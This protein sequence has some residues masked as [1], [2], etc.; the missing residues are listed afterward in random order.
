[1]SRT[2]Y[3]RVR[4]KPFSNAGTISRRGIHSSP[5]RRAARASTS[6][7]SS[8]GRR[9]CRRA[10]PHG[11][12][13]RGKCRRCDP[14]DR[15]RARDHREHGTGMRE[16]ATGTSRRAT[17]STESANSSSV[18]VPS[19]LGR[20]GGAIRQI[21]GSSCSSSVSST[22]VTGHASSGPFA[23]RM[24]RLPTGEHLR[25]STISRGST[26]HFTPVWTRTGTIRLRSRSSGFR[27]V[28]STRKVST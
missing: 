4:G 9:G 23:R 19:R 17:G 3:S 11:K 25:A 1:M 22:T 18:T 12:R 6:L 5:L 27:N 7:A 16:P 24:R 8:R 28:A 21:V 14:R 20:P 15:A 2:G 10:L 26:V 13:G